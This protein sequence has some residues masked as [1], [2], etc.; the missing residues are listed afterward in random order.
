MEL[1]RGRAA[2]L[3]LVA[4]PSSLCFALGWRVRIF[5]VV[6]CACRL[7]N[8]SSRCRFAARLNS[9]VRPHMRALVLLATALFAF[10]AYGAETNAPTVVLDLRVSGGFLGPEFVVTLSG[11]DTLAVTR[12]DHAAPVPEAWRKQLSSSEKQEILRLA[13]QAGDFE[14][15]CDQ[16]VPDGTNAVLRLHLPGNGVERQVA[17]CGAWPSG[18]QTRALLAAINRHLPSDRKVF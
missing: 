13:R 5:A 11:S 6:L 4:Q 2:E 1:F 9:G 3:H 12:I 16:E 8:H 10:L 18:H 7:T 17:L 14:L 15:G